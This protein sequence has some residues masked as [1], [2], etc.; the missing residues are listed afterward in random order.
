MKRQEADWIGFCTRCKKEIRGENY[1]A[2]KERPFCPLCW[3]VDFYRFPE[4]KYRAIQKELQ[5]YRDQGVPEET[6]EKLLWSTLRAHAQNQIAIKLDAM[7][8]IIDHMLK[9]TE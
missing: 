6:L 9:K 7:K 4:T 3:M 8:P 5:Q 1:C 2:T